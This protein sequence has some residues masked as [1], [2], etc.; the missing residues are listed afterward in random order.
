MNNSNTLPSDI[1]LNSAARAHQRVSG[2]PLGDKEIAILLRLS[3]GKLLQ[4]LSQ[5]L[6]PYGQSSSGYIGM[7]MLLGSNKQSLNP[8]ELAAMIGERRANMTRICDE[9]VGHGLVVRRT[10]PDDRRRVNLSLSD[11]GLAL[12][13]TI[14]PQSK[15]EIEKIFAIFAPEEKRQLTSMLSRL[16]H[17][18]DSMI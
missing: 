17:H 14:Q 9:L 5:R 7:M 12:L 10:D 3:I 8:S 13:E 4:L 2:E 1:P 6:E 11:K 18:L 16:N 15:N